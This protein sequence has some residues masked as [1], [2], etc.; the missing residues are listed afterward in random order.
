[1]VEPSESEFTQLRKDDV[2]LLGK[3]LELDVRSSTRKREVQKLV[4][5][6]L[7]VAKVFEQSALDAYNV[8]QQLSESAVDLN[9]TDKE[10]SKQTGS[11]PFSMYA[12]RGREGVNCLRT[13]VVFMTSYLL[14]LAYKGEGSIFS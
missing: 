7:V 12:R 1:M 5:E 2:I 3:H 9:N 13:P 8:T 14:F 6:Y 10:N 11:H 4:M